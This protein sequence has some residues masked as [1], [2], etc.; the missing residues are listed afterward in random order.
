MSIRVPD[1]MNPTNQVGE[2]LAVKAVAERVPPHLPLHIITDSEYVR[3]G[4]LKQYHRWEA[5]GWLT[6]KN[7]PLWK[8]TIARLRRRT[9]PVTIE[10]VKGHSGH[11]G[12]EAADELAAAGRL[13]HPSDVDLTS[14]PELHISGAELQSLTQRSAN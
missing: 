7:G 1:D 3:K 5:E 9:A 6:V 2:L 13:K 10:W 11:P 8:A 14:P 4:V 12:N